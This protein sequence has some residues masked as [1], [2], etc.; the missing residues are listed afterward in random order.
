MCTLPIGYDSFSP[1]LC[2]CTLDPG[3]CC[4][5]VHA[6]SAHRPAQAARSSALAE[7]SL[8][9]AALLVGSCRL[10]QP[11]PRRMPALISSL[12]NAR[13]CSSSSYHVPSLPDL[14]LPLPLLCSPP[15]LSLA[16]LLLPL[17]PAPMQ[18]CCTALRTGRRPTLACVPICTCDSSAMS[19]TLV[20]H[21]DLSALSEVGKR[22]VGLDRS[23]RI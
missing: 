3:P 8:P 15:S 23:L 16:A 6:F 20:Q 1:C 17:V 21:Q 13:E 18:L 11:L 9:G 4:A 22:K 14:L 2:A 5:C 10:H 19:W 12:P 7:G